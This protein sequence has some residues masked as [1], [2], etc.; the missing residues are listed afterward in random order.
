MK[1]AEVGRKKQAKENRRAKRKK[2]GRK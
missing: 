2:R 1:T